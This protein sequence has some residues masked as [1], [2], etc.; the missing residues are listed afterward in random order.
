L[1]SAPESG[2]ETEEPPAPEVDE[3]RE[4]ILAALQR[5]LGDAIVGSEIVGGDIWV[6]VTKE[7]WRAAGEVARRHGFEYFCFL[8]ALDWL[9]NPGLSGEKIWDPEA[10]PDEATP[11]ATGRA[12]GDARFQVFARLYDVNR[13]VG[14]TLK[15]DLDD[16]P[17]VDSWVPIFG[18]AD[19]HEREA[20]EMFGF[21]FVGHPGLRHLYLPGEFE[22]FP[23][24]KDFPL[25]AREVKPWPGLVDVEPMPGGDDEPAEGE[26]GTAAE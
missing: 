1:S 11:L 18:G 10:T 20:W 26:E 13:H 25:L 5:E 24:R 7:S 9:P 15:A 4:S 12:G 16:E 14:V 17:V 3:L 21:Q 19:W 2:T 23:M 6:R 8:S 22:G